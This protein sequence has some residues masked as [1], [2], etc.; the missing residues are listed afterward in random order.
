MQNLKKYFFELIDPNKTQIKYKLPF[1]WVF[2]SGA[3]SIKRIEQI[4]DP[5]SPTHENFRPYNEITS[6]RAG[7]IQWSKTISHDIVD[8]LTVP[9]SYPQWLNFNKYSNLVD[10]ELD[11]ASISQGVIIFSESI[12]AHTEIGMFSNITELHKNILIIAPEKYIKDD[13]SSFF[14]Y[15]AIR[16][17]RENELSEELTNIWSLEDEFI[18]SYTPEQL[19]RLFK[20]ISDHF[21]KIITDA[22]NPNTKLNCNNRHHR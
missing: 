1:I 22:G 6:F 15:G 13:N 9:E 5:L 8:N 19:N 16:K 2:G 11:I 20:E 10:F 14:N 4:K 3:E 17:I 21:L 18:H 7:F 12:G